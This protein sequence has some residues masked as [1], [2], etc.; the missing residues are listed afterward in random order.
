MIK[1]ED[2]K[3]LY[4]KYEVFENLN[5]EFKE[6]HIYGLLGKTE[7]ASQLSCISYLVC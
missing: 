4:G 5:L 3:F 7:P 6:N 1:I 2:M